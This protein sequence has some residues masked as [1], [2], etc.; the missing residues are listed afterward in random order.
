MNANGNAN[1]ETVTLPKQAVE[2]ALQFLVRAQLQGQEVQA[3]MFCTQVMRSALHNNAGNVPMA[4]E[5]PQHG[6]LTGADDN[7]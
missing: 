2:L 3:Y 4:P 5:A 6:H 1:T 7:V